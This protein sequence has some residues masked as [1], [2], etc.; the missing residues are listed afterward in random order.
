M[1]GTNQVEILSDKNPYDN[2]IT[3]RTNQRPEIGID[4]GLNSVTRM[5]LAASKEDSHPEASSN[6][7]VLVAWIT[8]LTMDSQY[9]FLLNS[10]NYEYKF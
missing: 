4:P 6:S 1:C 5:A 8:K 7:T 9:M 3:Q 10:S 2:Y